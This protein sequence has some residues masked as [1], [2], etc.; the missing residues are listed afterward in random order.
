MNTRQKEFLKT[1]ESHDVTICSGTP[2]SGK[3]FLS[4]FSFLKMLEKNKI[5]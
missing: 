5:E 1:I 2:G 4:L 3:T